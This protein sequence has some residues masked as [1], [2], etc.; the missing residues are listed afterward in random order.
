MSRKI[1]LPCGSTAYFD[2]DSGCAHRCGTCGAV[3]G[4]VGMPKA[5]KDK[6]EAHQTWEVLGGE[7]WDYYKD[8]F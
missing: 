6:M 2:L 4:S 7:P 1:E 8:T 5:C 3:V